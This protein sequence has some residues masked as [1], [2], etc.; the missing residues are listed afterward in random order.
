[1][2]R[3]GLFALV[4]IVLLAVCCSQP[5]KKDNSEVRVEA[6]FPSGYQT[7]KKI[8]VE[9]IIREN[10]TLAWNI[11]ANDIAL[12]KT[13]NEFPIGSVL[14]KEERQ[15]VEDV[16]GQ[17][18]PRDVQRVSVMFKLGSASSPTQTWRFM[19]FDPVTK[20]EMPRDKVDP[21]G[22]QFCHADAKDRDYVF[23]NIR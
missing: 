11:Y 1:M 21:E 9:P 6:V 8:N 19:A 10:E 16:G 15:L 14:V 20:A 2:D 12:S 4:T 17:K 23:S 13:G 3:I 22:C 7:W 18:K 5:T